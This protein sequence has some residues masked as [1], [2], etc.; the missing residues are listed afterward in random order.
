MGS[1]LLGRRIQGIVMGDSV[2]DVFIP[3]LIELYRQGRFPFDRL[4]AF[5]PFDQINQA[6]DDMLAKRA[7]K[8]IL[9]LRPAPPVPAGTA[10]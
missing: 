2:P 5:Y 1:I 8:P 9:R 10:A 6:I 3:Q 7:V 4:I